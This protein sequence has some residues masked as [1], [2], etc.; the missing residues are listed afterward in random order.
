MKTIYDEAQE[1]LLHAQA[2]IALNK[3]DRKK[4]IG[5]RVIVWDGSGNID[6][7]TNKSRYGIDPLFKNNQAI[8][9]AINC[10]AV[11]SNPMLNRHIGRNCDKLCDLL[12]KFPSGEEVYC[13]SEFVRIV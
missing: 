2:I 9:I 5:D 13:S 11:S 3:D 7:H 4:E 1:L 8:V 12:L 10:E 6:K